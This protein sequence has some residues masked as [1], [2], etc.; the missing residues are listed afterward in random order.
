MSRTLKLVVLLVMALGVVHGAVAQESQ[1]P[2]GAKALFGQGNEEVF[3]PRQ[4]GG[5]SAG[6]DPT[7]HVS[8]E[9][10]TAFYQKPEFPGIAYSLEVIRAG[11][12]TVRTV[13]DVRKYEFR[14]GDRIRIRLVP[15]FTGFAYVM[16][17][18][19]DNSQ[20]I[21][22]ANFGTT[23]NKV[24]AGRETYVPTTGWL[25]LT[26]PAGPFT[27]RVLFKP[28]E[29]DY[30]INKPTPN[31]AAARVAMAEAVDR[32]WQVMRGSKGFVFE[33]DN[34]YVN[35]AVSAPQP[36]SAKVPQG[37]TTASRT[38]QQA[39]D[40]GNYTTNYVVVDPDRWQSADPATDKPAIA[41]EV[42]IRHV[43]R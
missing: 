3:Y 14:T 20:L 34:S 12:T 36:A 18:K 8:E 42:P 17:A 40:H 23:E 13:E 31:P 16:E 5:S 27:M 15:N 4:Q 9:T 43:G 33:S 11:E 22:P 24:H 26:D 30:P 29:A 25:R 38:E 7:N 37:T 39:V 6:M 35:A 21:Y 1:P 41:I 28:G 32:E 2:K 19:Q 10:L